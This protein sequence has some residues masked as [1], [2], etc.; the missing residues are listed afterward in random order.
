MTKPTDED[1]G[2]REGEG[3]HGWLPQGHPGSP[4]GGGPGVG[5]VRRDLNSEMRDLVKEKRNP[6]GS[7]VGPFT[8]RDQ[9]LKETQLC[10]TS[11]M[12]PL[13]SLLEVCLE[14]ETLR[15]EAVAE[16]LGATFSQIVRLF[17]MVTRERRECAIARVAPELRHMVAE[18][19]GDEGSPKLF[20]ESFLV[21]LK[22]RNE[23]LKALREA[24][25]PSPKGPK[26][27]HGAHLPGE[28]STAFLRRGPF[29]Y[30]G[31]RDDQAHGR[32]P[33][34]A[35]RG[36]TAR[37]AA[38]GHPGSPDRE[39]DPG[40]AKFVGDHWGS[41]G[42]S[43][44][45]KAATVDYPRPRFSF[46]TVRDLN[47]EMRDLVKGKRNPDGSQVGPFTAR[48]QALKETQLCITSAMGPL[49]SLLEVCL[50]GE[51]LRREAVAERLGATF[52][53]MVRLFAMVIRGRRECAIARVAPELRHMVA[54]DPGDEGSPKLFGESFLVKLKTRNETLK[55]LREAEQPPPKGPKLRHGAHVPGEPSTAFL[56]QGDLLVQR[57][58]TVAEHASSAAVQCEEC[59]I[60]VVGAASIAVPIRQERVM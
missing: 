46:A 57:T 14:G 20:G 34:F 27:R 10:I 21:K 19:S 8:A 53:Q 13:V 36:G 18:D 43:E 9:A 22:T 15:R 52:S 1:R 54:E 48:D 25:H 4:E 50:E 31:H 30:R 56:R 55:A 47:S 3:L 39:V 12:G 51:T 32:G 29:S 37:V 11:A 28:P 40:L 59:G 49:V 2:S 42:R 17:A 58:P 5:E 38:Q 45:C 7:T 24:G 6:D 16:R 41:E 60:T 35:G 44:R 26:L 23:T 33:G